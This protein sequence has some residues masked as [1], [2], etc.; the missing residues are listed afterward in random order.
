MNSF[1]L[2]QH[3][4]DSVISVYSSRSEIELSPEYQR[5]SGI[6]TRRRQQLLVDSLLNGFDLPKFYFHSFRPLKRQGDHRY[7]YA[8]VD[9]KQRLQAIWDFIDNKIRLADDFVYVPNNEIELRG[10]TYSY[11]A[12]R[13]PE[14]RHAFDTRSLDIVTISTNDMEVIEELFLRLNESA[15][16]NAPE[17]RNAF[18]GPLPPVIR[19]V[20]S[21]RFFVDHIPFADMRYRYLDLAAKFLYIEH[22]N[23]IVNTKKADLDSFARRFRGCS[24]DKM[25]TQIPDMIRRTDSTLELMASVFSHKPDSLLRQVGMITLYYYLCRAILSE[26]TSKVDRVMLERFESARQ[27]N[28]KYAEQHSNGDR[29]VDIGLVE[30]DTHSQ[31]PNDAYALRARLRILLLYLAREFE[32]SYDDDMLSG[33]S[34]SESARR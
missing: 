15:P 30:F 3:P 16:L 14:I 20:G 26:R 11:L 7:R 17:K 9:G 19:R 8:I 12:R 24:E 31:T 23:F 29:G 21:H 2:G 18:G 4:D 34:V 27:A 6:W 32:V 13:H 1:R 28:R 22:S 10:E 33:L 5:I 25:E